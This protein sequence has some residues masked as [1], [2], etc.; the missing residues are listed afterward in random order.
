MEQTGTKPINDLLM[1]CHG[2]ISHLLRFSSINYKWPE[3]KK[4]YLKLLDEL[5]DRTH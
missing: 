4:A 3:Q 2:A 1:E 5:Y